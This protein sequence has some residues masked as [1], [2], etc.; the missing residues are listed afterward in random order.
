VYIVALFALLLGNVYSQTPTLD[1]IQVLIDNAK[2]DTLKLSYKISYA[3]E[4]AYVNPSKSKK[5]S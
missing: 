4:L 2:N 3:S 5:N 1:S